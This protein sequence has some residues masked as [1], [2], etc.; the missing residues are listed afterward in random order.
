MQSA[1]AA[2][3]TRS[4]NPANPVNPAQPWPRRAT[5]RPH[6]ARRTRRRT[7][8]VILAALLAILLIECVGFNMPFW[9]TR[10]ASTDTAAYA[11]T[12][13]S[14]LERTKEGMLR[15][16]DPT[17]AWLEVQADGTS[18]YARIDP[19]FVTGKALTV[20]H[21]RA[22]VNHATAGATSFSPQS[23]RSSYIRA[24][25]KG[26]LR[27]SIEEPKGSLIPIQA[28]RAN[29]S[30]PFDFN[31]I[32][33][34]LML[35]I[36]LIVAC[37][38]PGSRLWRI[39][40][41]TASN[42]QRVLGLCLVIPLA[43]LMLY[44]A[45]SQ[46]TGDPLVFHEAGG[47]TYDFD[48]Y[49]HIADALLNGRASLDLD[50]PKALA[51]TPDPYDTATRSKL[52]AEGVNPI[53]WDYVYY[54]GHWYSYF[55]V[56]PA[57]LL[58]MPFRAITGHMLSSG[59]AV[60][61]F[62]LVALV[63]LAL[64]VVRLIS[65]LAPKTSLAATSMA[66]ALML[67]GSNAGYLLFRR[68]FYSVP[69]AASLA[70]S[71]LGLWLWLGAAEPDGNGPQ[72]DAAKP[73]TS[74]N[75][76][77][78]RRAF[79]RWK[80]GDA[81]AL[82]LPKVG[83]GALCIA[84][85]F[86]CRPTFCL[87]AL[88]GIALFW[89]QIRAIGTV[90]RGR[91]VAPGKALLAP[92][93]VVAAALIPVLPLMAYNAVRFGSPLDFGNDYQFTV[94]DLTKYRVAPANI[95]PIVADYL[96]LPLRFVGQFPWIAL[97]KA[98]LP[99]WSYMEPMIGGLFAMCPLLALSIALPLLRRGAGRPGR[100]PFTLA[101]L[102]LGLGLTMF[103]AVLAGLGWRYMTDFGWLF[104]LAALPV[105]LRLL[106]EPGTPDPHG[107]NGMPLRVR[108]G[109]LVVMIAMLFTITVA[110][111]S[112]FTIGRHDALISS[113]PNLFYNVFAWFLQ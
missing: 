104:T 36:L 66:L 99:E 30:V 96:L 11:N 46:L 97:S 108:V 71:A 15:I 57:V 10:G 24:P 8:R 84:A 62:M 69:F 102:A 95:L 93:V 19:S 21:I 79:G 112:M 75:G 44:G 105:M 54:D 63:F 40:L 17:E 103:D 89:P 48:Q 77:P 34:G 16:T 64:L 39:P 45:G 9:R 60:L 87:T 14:G 80:V 52:L 86:G 91:T 2:Q 27:V 35:A 85:N 13:G 47:Y 70:F 109:R 37:W 41:D 107:E 67:I 92:A 111:L 98:S 82:S 101:V 12:M 55:G 33:V 61:L 51:D 78:S 59:A 90:L 53:Y 25:G 31:P 113:A 94:T 110:L 38:R 18:D 65:R 28:V 83:F 50:V 3:S 29:V 26:V 88:L 4:A 56:L 42:T 32:R 73:K 58:F 6:T 20:V 5:H 1:R 49:G 74:G 43:A 68:N 23:A 22:S 100:T 76:E 72:G 7:I 106:G 81:P